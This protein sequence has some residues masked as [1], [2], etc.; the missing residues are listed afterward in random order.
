MS[1]AKTIDILAKKG[2]QQFIIQVKAI[3]FKKML[4]GPL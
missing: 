3:F 4:A 2:G 1:N